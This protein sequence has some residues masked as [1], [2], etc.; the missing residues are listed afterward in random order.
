MEILLGL[1]GGLA[2]LVIRFGGKAAGQPDKDGK[3]AASTDLDFGA[4]LYLRDLPAR[5]DSSCNKMVAPAAHQQK[6]IT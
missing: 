3:V 1:L 4:S 5:L 2:R 6:W